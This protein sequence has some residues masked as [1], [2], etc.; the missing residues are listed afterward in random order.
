[1]EKDGCGMVTGV[2]TEIHTG[3]HYDG[4]QNVTTEVSKAYIPVFKRG[5]K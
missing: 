4:G 3:K 2:W 5:E 1:M